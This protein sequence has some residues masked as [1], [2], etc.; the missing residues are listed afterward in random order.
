[1]FSVRVDKT[2]SSLFATA[3]TDSCNVS[4]GVGAPLIARLALGLLMDSGHVIWYNLLHSILKVMG[5][6]LGVEQ[7][8]C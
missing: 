8:L 7:R 6:G 5:D 1:M 2:L 3:L 4:V